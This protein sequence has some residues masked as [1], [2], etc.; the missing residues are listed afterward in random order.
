MTGRQNKNSTFA[1][2]KKKRNQ[3]LRVPVS[4]RSI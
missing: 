2:S 4:A 1:L 3:C